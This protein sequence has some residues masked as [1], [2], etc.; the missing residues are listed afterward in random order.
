[1]S[2]FGGGTSGVVV[3]ESEFDHARMLGI[4]AGS[5]GKIDDPTYRGCAARLL[6]DDIVIANSKFDRTGENAV[7]FSM[8]RL[9]LIGNVFTNTYSY[10]W[11]GFT[12]GGSG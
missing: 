8:T 7:G 2:L 4:W 10:D 1:L 3:N 6:P 5:P 9:Q 12:A 11:G